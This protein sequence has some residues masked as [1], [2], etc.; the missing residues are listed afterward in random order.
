MPFLQIFHFLKSRIISTL[1]FLLDISNHRKILIRKKVLILGN[2]C[3]QFADN[4]AN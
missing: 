4:S 2:L 3:S 1:I